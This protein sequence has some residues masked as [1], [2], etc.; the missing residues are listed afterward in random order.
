M[1]YLLF[2]LRQLHG[3]LVIT[4]VPARLCE[5]A[6]V[7]FAGAGEVPCAFDRFD[8]RLSDLLAGNRERERDAEK[9]FI[10]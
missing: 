2:R 5:A 9:A 1:E 3:C 4:T 6:K 7:G 8:I 10:H